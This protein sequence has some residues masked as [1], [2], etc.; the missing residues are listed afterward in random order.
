MTVQKYTC[1]LTFLL[2]I[3]LLWVPQSN[4]AKLT[5]AEHYRE[6]SG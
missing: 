6:E 5:I 1:G 4:T 3:S 2:K